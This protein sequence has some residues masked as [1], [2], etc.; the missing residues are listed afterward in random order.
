[1][2]GARQLAVNEAA[3]MHT[4]GAWQLLADNEKRSVD[5]CVN[6]LL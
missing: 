6:P 4:V 2:V 1:M 3:G 5:Q